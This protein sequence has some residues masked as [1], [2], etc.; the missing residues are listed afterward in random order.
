MTSRSYTGGP[1]FYTNNLY[2]QGLIKEIFPIDEWNP[3]VRALHEH[4][5]TDV[6]GP[7]EWTD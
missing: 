6:D 5:T 1:V 2:L 4:L 7:C 3:D